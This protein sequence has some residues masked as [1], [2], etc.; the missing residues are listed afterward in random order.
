MENEFVIDLAI[1]LSALLGLAGLFLMYY[2]TTKVE[3]QLAED[4]KKC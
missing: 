3:E 4:N 1:T 2:L